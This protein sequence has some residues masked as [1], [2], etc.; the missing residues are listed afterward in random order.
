MRDSHASP[1]ATVEELDQRISAPSAAVLEAIRA[2]PGDF[3]VLGAGGKMGLHVCQMLRRALDSLGR[4]N[5]VI[6]VSRFSAPQSTEP[7]E[8]D[9][10][11][12]VSA[13]LSDPA[14]YASLP[15]AENVIFLAGVKFGTS[16]SPELLHRMNVA[17]PAMVAD[18][19]RHSRIVALS[20]GCVYAFTTPESGG[21][22]ENSPLDPPGEY[23]QS[24]LGREQA[25]SAASVQH[26]TPCAL[27]RLNYAVE[28]RYGVLVDIAQKV[29]AGL[30][31]SVDTGYVNVIWQGDATAQILRCLPLATSPPLVLNITGCETLSVRQLAEQFAKRFNKP[32][33]I[34]GEEAPTA[35][36]SNN[37]RAVEL[38]GKPTVDVD[39]MIDWIAAW[40][41]RGG[42]TLD[43]PTHFE[44]RDGAY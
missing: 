11:E 35:W 10:V 21:S 27:V 39:T 38:F 34:Q 31:V 13:D 6:A 30:P 44:N 22:T 20:T 25:F 7:F 29:F 40:L 42:P 28:L 17:M 26:Q 37:A 5:R 36:L 23:A 9:G 41:Q 12:V 19:F 8:R 32:A 16:S 15:A 4:V 43:K 24:C 33:V 1:P 3:A 14:A 18:H 2:C